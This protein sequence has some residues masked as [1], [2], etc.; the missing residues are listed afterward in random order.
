VVREGGK[1]KRRFP[2]VE[3][4]ESRD[5]LRLSRRAEKKKPPSQIGITEHR[6]PTP[7]T[8]QKSEKEAGEESC[9]KMRRCIGSVKLRDLGKTLNAGRTV[10]DGTLAKL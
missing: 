5:L 10:S 2:L 4:W 6:R 8:V 1:G 3:G 7:V 9:V